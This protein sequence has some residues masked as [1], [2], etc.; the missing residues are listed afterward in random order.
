MVECGCESEHAIHVRY[1]AHIPP[2][3]GLVECRCPIEHVVHGRY[4]AHIPT[5]NII[6][7]SALGTKELGHVGDE[8]RAP[9][10]NRMSPCLT[11]GAGG[12]GRTTLADVRSDGVFESCPVGGKT[13][14]GWS[15]GWCVGR[16]G[17]CAGSDDDGEEGNSTI[18]EFHDDDDVWLR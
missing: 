14:T 17:W 12:V 15:I 16:T 9:S 13:C 1:L 11:N 6:V 18:Q 10:A 8:R 5:S 7:E 4:R 2:R 3:N